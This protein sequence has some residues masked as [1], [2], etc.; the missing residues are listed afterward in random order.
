MTAT[1]HVL[2]DQPADETEAFRT[3]LSLAHKKTGAV[4]EDLLVRHVMRI[5]QGGDWPLRRAAL[6]ACLRRFDF[7]ARDELRVAARPPGVRVFGIYHTRRSRS[8]QR[9]Y[10]TLLERLD[11]LS[12]SCECADYLRGSLGLCK[13]LLT[14]IGDLHSR[15]RR[16]R[17]ALA[18]GSQDGAQK[19]PRLA[20][21][22]VRSLTG[23]GD[24]LERVRLE[25]S[26]AR[27]EGSEAVAAAHRYFRQGESGAL[28]LKDAFADHPQRRLALVEALLALCRGMGSKAAGR[29]AAHPALR[30]L[31]A[32]E[33]DRLGQVISSRAARRRFQAALRTLKRSLYPFQVEGVLQALERTRFLLADDMGLGKTAQAIAVCHALWH[34]GVVR[35]GLVIAPA[36]LKPQWLREWQLFTDAPAQ[37]VDGGPQ[38][39][40]RSYRT[41]RGFLIANYEQVLK[42][43]ELI[44]GWQP[45]IVVLDEAQRIKNWATKTAAY[46]K[47]L[48]PAFRL[49]L[50]GTPMENRIE[51]LASILDWVDDMALEPKWRLVPWH[52][53]YADG[54]SGVVGARNLDTLRQRLAPCMLRRVR[55]E[56]LDQLP[57]RTDTVIP[58]ELTPAQADEHDALRKPIAALLKITEH[59]PLT[60]QEFL[61]LMQLL[62]AQRIIANGLAQ[63]RFDEHWPEISAIRD[64]SPALLRS[65][66]SPK[67]LELREMLGQLVIDQQ[68]KVVVFSQWRRMLRLAHWAV[69]GMLAAQ[70]LRAAF[71]SGQEK[72]K[73]RTQNLVDFHDD[74]DLRVLLATDAG[75]VGLNLQRASNC[76]VNLELPWNPAVLEQRIGRIYRI[77]QEH[78]IDVY[79]LVSRNCIEERIAGLV[80]GKKALFEG[81]FDGT[82]DEVRFERGG[83]FMQTLSRIIKAAEPPRRAPEDE[84]AT[85]EAQAQERDLQQTLDT[86]DDVEPLAATA[87]ELIEIKPPG[88]TAAQLP[89]AQKLMELF[90]SLRITPAADG[91]VSIE[92]APEAAASLAAVFQG[93]ARMLGAASGSA[94]AG[95][96][97]Q[98]AAGAEA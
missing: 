9:P 16:M 11:P 92:A 30:P 66:D 23:P 74:P 52:T 88:A 64:P 40:R 33:K 31:L 29:R 97:A 49:V 95:A 32:Q 10:E 38:E 80:S 87:A 76:C 85:E 75:G 91:R 8:R 84:G 57:P 48:H 35:R 37:V 18:G 82:S 27:G 51:E 43:V 62:T 73:R 53:S 24:W 25:T 44:D 1:D 96:A 7:A 26:S 50:T 67:L 47:T 3:L 60:Q 69:E 14:V 15:P 12:G 45:G 78:P 20:W 34:C 4:P 90:S 83:S 41:Q 58:V 5:T 79:N 63:F 56:V 39:R 93:L 89:A 68:R 65:L 42:D 81:L 46:V 2:S 71:F 61:K 70:G 72:Q 6:E 55:R 22:P 13:H 21:D 59:R 86:A 94:P 36:S 98:P 19:W 54:R 17:Q 28:V 77:G